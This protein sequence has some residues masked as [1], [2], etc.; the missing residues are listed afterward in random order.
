MQKLE[1]LTNYVSKS[2]IKRQLTFFNFGPS[3]PWYTLVVVVDSRVGENEPDMLSPPP[4]VEIHQ[5]VTRWHFTVDLKWKTKKGEIQWLRRRMSDEIAVA[6]Y[7]NMTDNV[8]SRILMN[9]FDGLQ[10]SLHVWNIFY[11]ASAIQNR[12]FYI[13][14]NF[15][16]SYFFFS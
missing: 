15:G 1:P 12:S 10:R 7:G 6:E 5:L 13:N 8:S 3:F 9:S 4:G 16:Y 11:V 14:I 2:G